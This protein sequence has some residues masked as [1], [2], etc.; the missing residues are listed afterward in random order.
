MSFHETDNRVITETQFESCSV[1]SV[2]M[3]LQ[4]GFSCQL[5][6][7]NVRRVLFSE[8]DL[9]LGRTI[10]SKI[11]WNLFLSERNKLGSSNIG[12]PLISVIIISISRLTG[13]VLN[14]I[15]RGGSRNYVNIFGSNGMKST[16]RFVTF[17]SNFWTFSKGF[18]GLF[19][20]FWSRPRNT[21]FFLLLK[22]V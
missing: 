19:K 18:F 1:H 16:K 15:V 21:P 17:I 4:I 14:I 11:Q 12:C 22:V 10:W 20:N 9:N 3:A 5:H 8:S 13:K 7:M 6:R 2:R